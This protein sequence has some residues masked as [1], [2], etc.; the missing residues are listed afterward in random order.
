M[1]SRTSSP[2]P[3][4][5][6]SR[7]IQRKQSNHS[8]PSALSPTRRSTRSS[9]SARIPSPIP[10]GASTSAQQTYETRQTV[11]RS[12]STTRSAAVSPSPR[13]FDHRSKTTMP[14][15][16]T[17]RSPRRR[18]SRP[19]SKKPTESSSSQ[20]H[21]PTAI[22]TLLFLLLPA[23][24]LP[25]YYTSATF[26]PEACLSQSTL[27]TLFR[28]LK[29]IY[30]SALLIF[31]FYRPHIA[32]R[33]AY[34]VFSGWLFFVGTGSAV[35]ALSGPGLHLAYFPSLGSAISLGAGSLSLAW[36]LSL[37]PELLCRMLIMVIDVLVSCWGAQDL[38]Y[39]LRFGNRP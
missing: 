33:C 1:A 31:S 14:Q 15:S 39:E 18:A 11:S 22:L 23:L 2:L 5:K 8:S 26:I 9:L 29:S 38:E 32:L 6:R 19:T 24:Y 27:S 34:L 16:P 10:L 30:L 13:D 37:G 3:S 21:V 25:S 36:F 20:S 35:N 4:P 28:F 12:N 17:P 7:S